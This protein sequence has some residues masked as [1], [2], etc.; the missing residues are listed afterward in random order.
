MG[1]IRDFGRLCCRAT[2]GVPHKSKQSAEIASYHGAEPAWFEQGVKAVLLAPTA[3]NKQAFTIRGDGRKVSM[4][5]KNGM[6][7]GIDLGI[8]KYHFELGA[9][10][11]QFEWDS[12]K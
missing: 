5:C 12:P 9:G 2:Q 11:E 6:F 1:R 4:T 8:G 3:L 7:S 10:Q